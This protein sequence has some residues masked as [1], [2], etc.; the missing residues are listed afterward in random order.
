MTKCRGLGTLNTIYEHLSFLLSRKEH[1]L[2]YVT[3]HAPQP[4]Y[5][6]H[7]FRF[8]RRGNFKLIMVCTI[9]S[10]LD[11]KGNMETH[12]CHFIG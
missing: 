12:D 7:S 3:Q 11:N 1:N 10:I 8:C 4:G 6:N 5:S 9:N 2:F